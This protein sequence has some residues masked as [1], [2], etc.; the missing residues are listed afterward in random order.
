MSDLL[1]YSYGKLK[2]RGGFQSRNIIVNLLGYT[3]NGYQYSYH[4]EGV[5]LLS[6][7]LLN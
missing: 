4:L 2:K 6:L 5:R 3:G 7:L 1:L